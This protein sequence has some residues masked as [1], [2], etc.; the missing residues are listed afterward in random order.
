[1]AKLR[2][3]TRRSRLALAQAQQAQQRLARA[4]PELETELV[5]LAC[6]GDGGAT[7]GKD[8]YT[9]SLRAA[10]RG[11][12]ADCACH[13]L[14]DV[15]DEDGWMIAA[16]LPRA[17]HREALVGLDLARLLERERPRVGAASLRRQAQLRRALPRAMA[18]EVRGNIDTRLQKLEDGA[19]DALLLACAGLERLGWADRIAERLDPAAFLPPPGQGTVVLE[20]RS[21]SEHAGLLSGAD[22][23]D[24]RRMAEAERAC[25]RTI[26]GDC[27]TPL[28]ALARLLEDGTVEVSCELSGPERSATGSAT[29]S[30]PQAAGTAAAERMLEAGGRELL[31]ALRNVAA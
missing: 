14:K 29:G 7:G 31:A 2:I 4:H 1:M 20:C 6:D 25:A 24:A 19:A 27:Q 21:D 28:G 23:P 30:D 22:D 15:E 12:D 3:A 10:I 26:D 9:A 11:G 18:V 8:L 13:S 5:P 16:C 17:D